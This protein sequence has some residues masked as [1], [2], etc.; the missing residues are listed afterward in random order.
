M[1]SSALVL[2]YMGGSGGRGVRTLPPPLAHDVGFLTL[3][4]KLGP[5]LDP[6]PTSLLGDIIDALP[7]LKILDP[8][9]Q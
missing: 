2:Q 8:P 3:D 6:P 4:P 7:P 9:L 5:L 1:D